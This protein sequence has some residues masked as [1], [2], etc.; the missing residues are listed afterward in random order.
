M[1]ALL[2]YI[3]KMLLEAIK[4]FG[5]VSGIIWSS[6]Q[7]IDYFFHQN[8]AIQKYT[9]NIQIIWIPAL[10][11][12]VGRLAYVLKKDLFPTYKYNEKRIEIRVGD[13]LKY[14]RGT[15]VVGVNHQLK[16]SADDIG[17]ASIHKQLIDKHGEETINE[18][19]EK[20]KN[21]PNSQNAFF[22]GKVGILDIIFIKMSDWI[23]EQQVVTSTEDLEKGLH[24]LFHQQADLQIREKTLYCPLLGKGAAASS[25]DYNTVIELIIGKFLTFQQTR[26]SSSTDRIEKLVI[27]VRLADFTKIDHI[28]LHEEI[29]TMIS[30]CCSCKG[31]GARND[32]SR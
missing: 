21:G 26:D 2:M 17:E 4:A 19:F 13:I 6:I 29:N 14:K 3:F 12:A 7:L 10:V 25:L 23:R 30:K 5:T 16:T 28:R 31:L 32:Y 20:H 24:S 18:I 11:F 27:V 22:Q 15:I 8:P 1:K 9:S